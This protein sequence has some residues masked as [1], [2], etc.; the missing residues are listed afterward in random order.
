MTVGGGAVPGLARQRARQLVQ[1]ERKLPLERRVRAELTPEPAEGSLAEVHQVRGLGPRHRAGVADGLPG[2][3]GSGRG[4]GVQR[5]EV[6]RVLEPLADG[7]LAEG[8]EPGE[9]VLL[10]IV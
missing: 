1:S 8:A 7:A 10:V 4:L 2:R 5:L 6:L 9:G 3:R